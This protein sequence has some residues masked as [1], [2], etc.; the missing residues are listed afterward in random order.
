MP[1]MYN[2]YTSESSINSVNDEYN[3]YDNNDEYYYDDNNDEY[4]YDDNNDECYY[5]D[6]EYPASVAKLSSEDEAYFNK[7][8]DKYIRNEKY[9]GNRVEVKYVQD[10]PKP[11]NKFIYE[12]EMEQPIDKSSNHN[13]YQKPLNKLQNVGDRYNSHY[14]SLESDDDLSEIF[15]DSSKYASHYKE[16]SGLSESENDYYK[17]QPD[18]SK[19]HNYRSQAVTDKSTKSS[20]TFSNMNE[21][22]RQNKRGKKKR[23]GIIKK[24]L[25]PLTNFVKK[26]D[27][28]YESELLKT[29]MAN[30]VNKNSKKKRGFNK[31]IVDGLTI[32]SPVLAMSIF[33]LLFALQNVTPGIVISV[34]FVVLALYY[35]FHKYKKCKH[36]CKVYGK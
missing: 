33:L 30:V 27:A 10:I 4:Y 32:T 31:K 7:L 26:T 1:Q 15:V 25:Y 18:S 35:V 16:Q 11:P 21:R 2:V 36:L 14:D 3:N 8:I 12:E 17:K 5:Y 24:V 22:K 20:R 19:H 9:P 28:I 29:L 13:N 34:F 23:K 6:D